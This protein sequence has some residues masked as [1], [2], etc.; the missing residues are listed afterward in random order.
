MT[1]Y[2]MGVAALRPPDPIRVLLDTEVLYGVVVF[3]PVEEQK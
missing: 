2:D 1:H 3:E